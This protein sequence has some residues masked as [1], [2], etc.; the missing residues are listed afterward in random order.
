ME[1][2]RELQ[3][4]A[5]VGMPSDLVDAYGTTINGMWAAT[6]YLSDEYLDSVHAK[7][8]R[9]LFSIPLTALTPKFYEA[10]EDRYLID[11]ACRDIDGNT[12]LVP[13]YYWESLPVYSICFYS[14]TFRNYLIERCRK[15]IERGFDVVNLDEIQ[16]SIGLM[17]RDSGSSGFCS[18]CLG[19]FKKHLRE[20]ADTD[21]SIA[22]LEDDTLRR[23]LREDD[24]LYDQYR[25]FHYG[26]AYRVV[27]E[28]IQELRAIAQQINP[29]F[30][31]TANMG[32]LG[33][34]VSAKG[35]LWGLM[36]GE[37]ID[38]VMMENDYKPVDATHLLL[39][40]GKFTAWYRLG[41]A[42]SS[43]APVWICPSI[44]VPK[45]M[46]GEKRTTY[47]TLMFLEAYA[48]NGRWGY[49]WW[50]GVDVETRIEATAPE[51]LKH[52]TNLL[53]QNREYF[54]N[55]TTE[56]AIAI[57]YLNSSMLKRPEAH[58]KYLALAQALSEAGYQYDVIY[59]GDNLYTTDELD[60]SVLSR[61]KAILLPEAQNLTASQATVLDQYARGYGFK[62]I[63]FLQHPSQPA[64]QFG[65]VYEENMLMN[66]WKEYQDVDRSR[67]E[68][69]ISPQT[70]RPIR[71]SHPLVN[72]SRYKKGDN[73]ILHFI[74]YDYDQ[75]RD[76]VTPVEELKVQL[77]WNGK[78]EP[79]LRW[80]SL[81]GEKQLECRRVDGRLYFTVPR[82]DLY[83]L[84]VLS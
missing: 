75:S 78:Q 31:I 79:L 52:Y 16:T 33:N 59:A 47:Y 54:E 80:I 25:R 21:S 66:F 69:C 26:E 67:I 30:A 41:G 11:Q 57:L 10:Q 61:Y 6:E 39:P 19:R 82:L 7:G 62:L 44:H 63:Q 60:F 17:D 73:T 22:N 4:I 43:H 68:A 36:W 70:N 51:Q 74:N 46:A 37:L 58:F 29:K 3:F 14:S 45:Q 5:A 35:E 24:T 13:W 83:G 76:F 23:R 64:V 18:E 42:F 55:L 20:G 9:A 15:G 40:R 71:T 81:D 32:Y 12:S 65:S 38:F 49:Y 28:F 77:P 1:W 50:P 27:K 8:N 72:I 53:K 84:A 56:N 2:Y 34:L 48:N